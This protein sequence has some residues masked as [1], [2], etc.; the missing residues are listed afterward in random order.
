V[1]TDSQVELTNTTDVAA[2]FEFL[3]VVNAEN[4]R[5]EPAMGTV[6]AFG[7]IRCQLIFKSKEVNPP[8]PS[9]PKNPKNR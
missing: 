3:P 8:K 1:P 9:N 4:I 7:T 2:N 5:I 6:P